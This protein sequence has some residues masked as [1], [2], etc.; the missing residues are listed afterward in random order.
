MK[1]LLELGAVYH[2]TDHA[3]ANN[4]LFV[5][6][7]N[8][9]YFLAKYEE[10]M[11]WVVKT[12]AYCLMPNHVHFVIQ[13]KTKS[14]ML[15]APPELL[16]LWKWTSESEILAFQK[17]VSKQFSNLLNGYAQAINLQ[18]NRIGALF[19]CN[20]ERHQ[21]TTKTYFLNVICYVHCNAVKHG[22]CTDFR[23]WQQSSYATLLFDETT[24]FLYRNL[25]L[26]A[27]GGKDRFDERHLIWK[28]SNNI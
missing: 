21:V 20:F 9:R 16:E 11:K 13:V 8:Y 6:P 28:P 23:E 5:A 1:E 19:A 3:V 15:N 14:E 10:K 18:R 4:N 26:S 25:V 27:F 17:R 7:D 12:M 22:F 2:I 24:T